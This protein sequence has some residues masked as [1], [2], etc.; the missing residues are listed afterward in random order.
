LSISSDFSF[1]RFPLKWHVLIYW[2]NAIPLTNISMT[3]YNHKS[4]YKVVCQQLICWYSGNESDAFVWRRELKPR[5]WPSRSR[6]ES[7]PIRLLIEGQSFLY[8]SGA[9]QCWCQ[10]QQ[11]TGMRNRIGCLFGMNYNMWEWETLTA[12]C[13]K[14]L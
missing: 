5:W 13:W 11:E 7:I 3:V 2:I 1:T 6:K 12:A 8:K 4:N 9:R 10:D 14:W